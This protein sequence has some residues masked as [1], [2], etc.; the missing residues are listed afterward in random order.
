[1]VVEGLAELFLS[2]DES[3]IK[4]RCDVQGNDVASIPQAFEIEHHEV[5]LFDPVSDGFHVFRFR[6]GLSIKHRLTLSNVANPADDPLA[7]KL[8]VFVGGEASESDSDGGRGVI[9]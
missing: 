3:S 9:F 6:L 4:E 8:D 1:M 7:S 2:K 5:T